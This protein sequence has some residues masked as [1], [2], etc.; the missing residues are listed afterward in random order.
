MA[1]FIT[2][3]KGNASLISIFRGTHSSSTMLHNFLARCVRVHACVYE[4]INEL[5]TYMCAHVHAW[6]QA[7]ESLS[8]N[9]VGGFFKQVCSHA[10]MHACM[11]VCVSDIGCFWGQISD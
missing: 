2:A 7:G 11:S 3:D 8:T 9:H 10:F 6:A 1:Y 4:Y 5:E